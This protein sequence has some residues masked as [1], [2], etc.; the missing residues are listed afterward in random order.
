MSQ[1]QEQAKSDFNIVLH[2]LLALR[3][4][5][6][7]GQEKA[8]SKQAFEL[9]L[10]ELLTQRENNVRIEEAERHR[11]EMRC[12]TEEL[13]AQSLKVAALE[14]SGATMVAMQVEMR[15]Q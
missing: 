15:Q 11:Q 13:H 10:K 6:T 9:V 3:Q 14:A 4:E 5:R 7:G 1:E 2:E 8:D 12:Q